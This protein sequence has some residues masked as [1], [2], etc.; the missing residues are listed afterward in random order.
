MKAELDRLMAETSRNAPAPQAADLDKETMERLSAL[1]YVG[2]PVAVQE[3][4]RR[5][6][7]RWPTPRTS[8]PSS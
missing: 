8:S 2:A 4:L 7:A 1:G 6:A 5:R 3:G